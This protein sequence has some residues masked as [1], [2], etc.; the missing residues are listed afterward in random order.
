[1]GHRRESS[2]VGGVKEGRVV[3]AV[4]DGRVRGKSGADGHGEVS[5]MGG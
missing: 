3:E 5:R 4:R 1:M 2:Y